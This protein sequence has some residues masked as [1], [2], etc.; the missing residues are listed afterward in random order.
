MIA[1][2]P[3]DLLPA[4]HLVWGLLEQAAQLDMTVFEARYRA[5]G[6]GGVPYDPRMMCSLLLYCYCKGARSSREIEMATYDDVGAR[7]ICCGEHPDHASVARFVVRHEEEI[8]GLLPQS[9]T[10]CAREGLVRVDVVAGDGT[11]LKASASMDATV[12]VA[13]LE[14]QIADLEALAAAEV[15]AWV[16]QHLAADDADAAVPAPR[17][18]GGDGEP[19]AAVPKRAAQTLARRRHARAQADARA[20]AAAARDQPKVQARVTELEQRLERKLAA[21]AAA[22]AQAEARW[23]RWHDREAAAAARGR[24]VFGNKPKAP[25]QDRDVIRTREQVTRIRLQLEAPAAP[26]GAGPD[27]RVNTTDPASRIMPLKKGGYDQLFNVQA[28]ATA[29]TQVI[30]AIMRHDSPCDMDALHPLLAAARQVLAAAGITGKIL[31]AVFDTGYASSANFTADPGGTGLYVAVTRDA[32]QAGR[33]SDGRDPASVTEPGWPEM[34]A[35]L[36]TPEGQ[37]VYKK[38]SPTIEPVFAQLTNRLGHDLRYRGDLTDA[39][40]SLWAASHNILKAITAAAARK[41]RQARTAAAAIPAA[42]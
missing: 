41:A 39:E 9:V 14:E 8:R 37:A 29:G 10:A 6:Q 36:A 31:K 3:R 35:R 2:D 28:L 27:A 16:Q 11:K 24:N 4:G 32:R 20:R 22:L 12:T 26:A 7:V 34:T 38:R 40:L 15:E 21:A 42:A 25:E 19:P 33:S 17:P 30:I 13:K 23:Q 1:A 18:A 5:D